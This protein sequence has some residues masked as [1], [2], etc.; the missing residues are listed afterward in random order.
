MA[1]HMVTSQCLLAPPLL[2]LFSI[3]VILC[4]SD[5]RPSANSG[6]V[7]RNQILDNF[8]GLVGVG[9]SKPTRV[10]MASNRE[11]GPVLIKELHSVISGLGS[12]APAGVC[13][14]SPELPFF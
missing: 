2:A 7:A 3:F 1:G 12:F 14:H 8:D 9:S 10:K 5:R 13:R 6:P 4:F 11:I